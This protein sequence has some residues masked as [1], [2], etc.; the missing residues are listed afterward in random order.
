MIKPS[1]GRKN[2]AELQT[3]KMFAEEI[4]KEKNNNC[5]LEEIKNQNND[6][7]ILNKN[8]YYTFVGRKL[9]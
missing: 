3:N 7:S 8:T 1:F 6:L 9:P 2:N 4:Q 5:E